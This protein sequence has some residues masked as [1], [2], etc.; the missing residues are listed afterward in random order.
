MFRTILLDKI[1]FRQVKSYIILLL[2]LFFGFTISF[3]QESP[4][5]NEKDSL[6]YQWESFSV[7]FGGFITGV[8]SDINFGIKQLGLGININLEDALGLK[9]STLALR[10]TLEYNFG[11][12]DRSSVRLGYFGLYRNASKILET[13]IEI[14][15]TIFP[16][17]TDVSSKLDIMIIK[18]NYDYSFYM[19]KRIKLGFTVG[20]F[21]LPISFSIN[22]LGL[23]G[24]SVYFVAPLPIIGIKSSFAVTPKIFI[25][26][27]IEILYLKIGAFSGNI[28]DLD[29]RIEYNPWKHIGFGLGVNSHRMTVQNY[30]EE[31]N[32]L[33][34]KGTIKNGYTGLLF[35]AKY[36]F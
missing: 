28:M 2:L 36:Y 9:T 12:R 1:A 20:L 23:T 19:D 31:N 35:F 3:A 5:K 10:G 33:D 15:D 8:N 7:R 29:L 18:A 17:G 16:I 24:K 22:V 27:S 13:N 21:I 26:Q 14:G 6:N 30:S 4:S 25:N 34:F 11:K 32:G